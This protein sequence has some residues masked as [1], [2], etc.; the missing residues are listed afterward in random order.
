MSFVNIKICLII[1]NLLHMQKLKEK[2]LK[3]GEIF[4][5]MVYV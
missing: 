2:D 4:H 5:C 1:L 3:K